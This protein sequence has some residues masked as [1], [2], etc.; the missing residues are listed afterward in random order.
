M[1]LI[2]ILN[3][4]V[5]SRKEAKKLLGGTNAY[6]KALRDGNIIFINKTIA[7]NGKERIKRTT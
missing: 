4:I 1:I 2:K 7:I 3:Q 6:N 5:S